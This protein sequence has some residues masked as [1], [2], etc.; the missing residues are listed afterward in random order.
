MNL[1]AAIQALPLIQA[2]NSS[3]KRKVTAATADKWILENDKT[4]DASLWL[5]YERSDFHVS[6]L[7]CKVCK[8]FQGKL[9][10]SRNFNTAFIDGSPNLRTSCFKDHA[11]TDM[12]KRAMCLLKKE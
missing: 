1:A 10:G 8:T 9:Q 11:S 12:H 3:K 4:L 6:K 5:D 7:L 2:K